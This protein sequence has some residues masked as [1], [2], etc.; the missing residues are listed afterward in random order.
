M[1]TSV[2]DYVDFTKKNQSLS[3]KNN[4]FNISGKT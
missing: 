3:K 1:W 2:V 4:H